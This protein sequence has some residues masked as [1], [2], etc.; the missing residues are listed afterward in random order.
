[1]NGDDPTHWRPVKRGSETWPKIG[2]TRGSSRPTAP[3]HIQPKIDSHQIEW[4]PTGRL[5]P[6][7]ETSRCE[8]KT[9]KKTTS[10][11]STRPAGAV[12][13]QL[14]AEL[15]QNRLRPNRVGQSPRTRGC[16]TGRPQGRHSDTGRSQPAVLPRQ[17]RPI[18]GL[19]HVDSSA[20]VHGRHRPVARSTKV[21]AAN[22]GLRHWTHSLAP[23]RLSTPPTG[24]R[25]SQRPARPRPGLHQPRRQPGKP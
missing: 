19:K 2:S 24:S 9:T 13:L 20:T 4:D 14:P 17:Q 16:A 6:K 10:P 3:Y 15:A 25:R 1:L 7:L 23:W 12:G 5:G 21:V 18:A 8:P 11:K 22:P